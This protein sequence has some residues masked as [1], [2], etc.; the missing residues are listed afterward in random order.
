MNAAADRGPSSS[1]KNS[2]QPLS[3]KE[4]LL[5]SLLATVLGGLLLAAFVAIAPR[6]VEA[7]ILNQILYILLIVW[8]LVAS[9]FS[10]KWRSDVLR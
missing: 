4:Y 6:L 9:W 8:G 5:P 1:N 2:S 10:L 7:D 3:A